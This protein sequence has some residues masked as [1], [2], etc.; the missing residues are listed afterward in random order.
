MPKYRG[1]LVGALLLWVFLVVPGSVSAAT[2]YGCQ[3]CK[4][5]SVVGVGEMC[6]G[7]GHQENGDGT[8]CTETN[9][10]PWPNGPSCYLQGGPC[11]NVVVTD[12]GG[13]WSGGGGSGACNVGGG[14]FCPAECFSCGSGRPAI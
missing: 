4:Y 5:V 12:G 8:I 10:A 7:V 2:Y 11:Y 9:D 1:T 6:W 13:G 14:Q 3:I